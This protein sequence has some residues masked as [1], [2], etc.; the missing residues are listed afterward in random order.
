MDIYRVY[1]F[2]KENRINAVGAGI[3]VAGPT[4]NFFEATM[5]ASPGFGAEARMAGIAVRAVGVVSVG[6]SLAQVA[7][8]ETSVGV[9]QAAKGLALAGVGAIAGGFPGAAIAG[10]VIAD[11]MGAFGRGPAFPYPPVRAE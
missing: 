11:G 7:S 10:F 9:N 6:F 4:T 1:A 8:A 3:A 5:T 2:M